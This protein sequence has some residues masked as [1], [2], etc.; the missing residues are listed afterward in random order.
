MVN[1]LEKTPLTEMWG[2]Y[3]GGQ[4]GRGQT[5][6]SDGS[7]EYVPEENS[8]GKQEV[9]VCDL[10]PVVRAGFSSGTFGQRPKHSGMIIISFAVS[11]C[12][13]RKSE[14]KW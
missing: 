1:K 11:F 5:T 8:A 13:W 10:E 2:S 14:Q 7:G 4:T 6:T 12:A 3:S 9:C